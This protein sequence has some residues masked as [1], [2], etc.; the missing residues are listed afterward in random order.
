[1]RC[2]IAK[3]N[4]C[5]AFTAFSAG[6]VMSVSAND[7]RVIIQTDIDFFYGQVR[8]DAELCTSTAHVTAHS[9]SLGRRT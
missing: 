1:M 3:P 8:N 4:F 7:Q 9:Q 2:H 6:S 5:F